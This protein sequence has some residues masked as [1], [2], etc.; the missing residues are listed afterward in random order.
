MLLVLQT[1]SEAADL[2]KPSGKTA[3]AEKTGAF[4][5]GCPKKK[6]KKKRKKTP[7]AR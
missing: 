2:S 6:K 1:A 4:E 5:G 7:P 3:N